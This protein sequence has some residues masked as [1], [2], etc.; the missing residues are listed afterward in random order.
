M[1]EIR[2]ALLEADVSLPIVKEFI[3]E[4]KSKAL[5]Q[6]LIKSV[7]P[8]QMI[9]KM[10]NDHL[11][12]ILSANSRNFLDKPLAKKIML[13]G[14]Q[15]A[16]KTTIAA[17]IAN[18]INKNHKAMLC[19][20][21]VYRPAA[22]EQLHI[23]SKEVGSEFFLTNKDDMPVDI[24]RGALEHFKKSDCK[25][26]ILD[27]AGRLHVD[28]NMMSEVMELYEE[29]NP[30]ETLLVV[31][32]MTGQDAINIAKKFSSNIKLTG[33]VM[34]RMDA[35]A[36][37]GC[38]ISMSKTTGLPIVL[39]GVG[40]KINDVEIFEPK[41]LANRILGMGDIVSLVEKAESIINKQ[42]VEK[43]IQRLAKGKFDFNDLAKQINQMNKMG[44]IA[45]M[46]RMLPGMNDLTSQVK[47]ID[48]N[49]IKRQLAIIYSM[50]KKERSDYKIIK[51][52]QKRR[53][54]SGSGTTIQEINRLIKNF[55]QMSLFM[56]QMKNNKSF[57]EQFRSLTKQ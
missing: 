35:D 9:I 47:Q 39:L 36:R 42:D 27:T 3:E 23:L 13:V 24:V 50:T 44:G 57:L 38:A 21:D 14:L 56:K 17:K 32:A 6:E 26:I 20:C 5:G 37:G 43:D 11:T 33:I 45:N 46:L 30:D 40:E 22:I 55:E 31:D 29:V 54:A 49:A 25:T 1:R 8:D 7:S 18:I 48:D 15:G 34:T 41:R 53:I 2:I 19:S 4:L 10:V 51:G 52:S 28:E 16:G 12:A